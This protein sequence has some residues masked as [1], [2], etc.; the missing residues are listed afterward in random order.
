MGY[1]C[2]SIC[3]YMTEL[4]CDTLVTDES[5][6]MQGEEYGND[7]VTYH[8]FSV[9]RIARSM[10]WATPSQ[11]D[12]VIQARL[13]E[14]EKVRSNRPDTLEIPGLK[15]RNPYAFIDSMPTAYRQSFFAQNKLLHPELVV[16]PSGYVAQPLPYQLWRDDWVTGS[17]LLCFLVLVYLYSQ[18]KK[19]FM[20]QARNFVFPTK[21]LMSAAPVETGLETSS[22]IFFFLLLSLQG[23][24]LAF[25]YSQY[26]LSI[27]LGQLSPYLLLGIYI[28]CW[29]AY[30]IC[31]RILYSFT[32]WIFFNKQQR[33]LWNESYN[34][35]I[36]AESLILFPIVV[37]SVYF[38]PPLQFTLYA[39][40]TLL[41]GVKALMAYKCFS[42]FFKNILGA[43]H[44]IV[45]L[46]ALELSPLVII[47]LILMRI[48]DILILKF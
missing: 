34:F 26:A 12:S 15:A 45:Y 18:A 38:T 5:L 37:V 20:L 9:W 42:I 16:R 29:L 48:T 8:G 44:L 46:C 17:L 31:K 2:T 19:F 36:C 41:I 43:L 6:L 4:L 7:T 47:G 14:R 39:V 27:F 40:L 23:G 22:V 21:E 24:L 13:P 28:S 32:N 30:F 11:L 33:R 25:G 3:R 1:Q 35:L 10:P